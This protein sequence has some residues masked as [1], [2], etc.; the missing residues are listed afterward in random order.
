MKKYAIIYICTGGYSVFWKDFF[1]SAEQF[2][3]VDAIKDYYV[4]TDDNELMMINSDHVYTYY[5]KKM[6]WPYDTLLRWDRICGIQDLLVKYDY[7]V[8]CNANMKFLDVVSSA[9]FEKTSITLCSYTSPADK[10]DDMPLERRSESKAY[11]PYGSN[12]TKYV[13]GGFILGQAAAFLKMA[14]ELREWTEQDLRKGIIPVW[15]DE[16][17]L[18]AY[19]HLYST[20]LSVYYVGA[21]FVAIEERLKSGDAPKA[22]FRNKDR[23]GGNIGIRYNV[24][25][26]K[27][28]IFRRKIMGKMLTLLG[29]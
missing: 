23:Y 22:I 12:H 4:F 14:R 9:I 7:V 3:L 10:P 21:E 25:L 8:F 24:T 29:K 16:S 19:L 1:S 5:C 27:L 20:E 11:V 28:D 18:N 6:G 2:F 15:H 26:G 13:A 17:M